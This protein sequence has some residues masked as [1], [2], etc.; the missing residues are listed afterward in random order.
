MIKICTRCH[1]AAGSHGGHD[2][3][4][5]CAAI[6]LHCVAGGQ[7]YHSSFTYSYT[8]VPETFCTTCGHTA[9]RHEASTY[10]MSCA[11][12]DCPAFS[13]RGCLASPTM[14][15]K[16]GLT[17]PESWTRKLV[18][19]IAPYGSQSH[20]YS[21]RDRANR[22]PIEDLIREVQAEAV[23]K[24]GGFDLDRLQ[25]EEIANLRA[26]IATLLKIPAIAIVDRLR[27]SD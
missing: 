18:D 20:S 23:R 13:A 8:V 15:A 12:C 21:L 3:C 27:N 4:D 6:G 19:R 2:H 24:T 1:H 7:A 25:N 14:A 5:G 9:T 16:L 10:C 26:R 17:S 11:D 22:G